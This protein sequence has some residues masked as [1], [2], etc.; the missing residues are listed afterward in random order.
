MSGISAINSGINGVQQGYA[1]LKQ[2]AHE[3]A[4]ANGSNN[5]NIGQPMVGLIQDRNQVAASAEVI[6]ASDETL[7][8]L[9]DIMA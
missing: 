1:S 5:Q 3:I 9:L 2:N 8:T 7:G 6:K 4:N